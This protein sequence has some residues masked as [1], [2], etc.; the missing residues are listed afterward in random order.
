[1]KFIVESRILLLL[2]VAAAF[3]CYALDD[4]SSVTNALKKMAEANRQ[5]SYEGVYSYEFGGAL[6]TVKVFHSV[7]N[8]QEFERIVHLNGPK[9]EVIRRGNNLSCQRLGDALLRGASAF[10]SDISRGHIETY[11]NLYLKG[12]ERVAGREVSM[13]HVVPKDLYRYGYALG[14][15]KETGLLLQSMLI[16]N[17]KK[18]LERFQFVDISIGTLVDDMSLEPSDREHHLASMDALPC[19][20][21]KGEIATDANRHWKVSWVPPGFALSGYQVS[22]DTHRQTLVFT[23][24]LAVFSVFV[25]TDEVISIPSMQAQRGATVA[26]LSHLEHSG[27]NYTICVVGEIPVETAK[28]VAHSLTPL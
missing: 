27:S 16:A 22:P 20:D 25:D 17:N 8:G 2:I 24:G 1:M 4:L 18:V 7:R 21:E 6:K 15:D 5:L 23:D 9:R 11:Y 14:I 19:V 28:K 12:D 26:F 10:S 13:V 3:P